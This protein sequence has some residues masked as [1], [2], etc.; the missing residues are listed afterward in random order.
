MYIEK[1]DAPADIAQLVYGRPIT[2]LM[3][4]IWQ[5]R[6]D[7]QQA[8]D[9]QT[10]TGQEGFIN[11]CDVAV[12]SEYGISPTVITSGAADC[13]AKKENWRTLIFLL[14][15]R[16]Q[17]RLSGAGQWLPKAVRDRA[18]IYWFRVMKYSARFSARLATDQCNGVPVSGN[19]PVQSDRHLAWVS[20]F[21]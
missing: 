9:L 16:L 20:M 15:R 5:N 7:L 21:E 3:F 19:I 1:I 14:M 8:F 2:N 18:K 17:S 12:E 11:W 4:L 13:V 10:K 6:R